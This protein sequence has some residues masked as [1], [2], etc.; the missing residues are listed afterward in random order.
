MANRKLSVVPAVL[1]LMAST[2]SA[3]TI[4]GF[5]AE[6]YDYGIG[7][8]YYDII[9]SILTAVIAERFIVPWIFPLRLTSS[10]EV[11]MNT[12]LIHLS[13]GLLTVCSCVSLNYLFNT[14]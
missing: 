11:D 8:W 1:S 14:D 6:M 10:F 13:V 7:Q 9:K 2:I 5:T 4:I 12:C 3:M